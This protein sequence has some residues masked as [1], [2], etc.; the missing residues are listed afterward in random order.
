MASMAGFIA[1][2]HDF[3]MNEILASTSQRSQGEARDPGDGLT[4]RELCEGEI[5]AWAKQRLSQ[6]RLKPYDMHDVR[7]S[8]FNKRLVTRF[9]KAPIGSNWFATEPPFRPRQRLGIAR[10]LECGGAIA[11]AENDKGEEDQK[12]GPRCPGQLMCCRY[13]RL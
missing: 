6:C 1:N 7:H 9:W 13:D 12:W 3:F 8:E 11:M 4:A 5:L 2:S 10:I